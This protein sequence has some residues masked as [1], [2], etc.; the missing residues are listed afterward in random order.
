MTA[1]DRHADFCKRLKRSSFKMPWERGL[2][3]HEVMPP[4]R[5]WIH[6]GAF[7]VAE[8]QHI[9]TPGPLQ[10]LETVDTSANA[11]KSCHAHDLIGK[12]T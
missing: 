2:L 10:T 8:E 6:K 9:E 11:L 5:C 4:V 12:L 1:V 7:P 3:G